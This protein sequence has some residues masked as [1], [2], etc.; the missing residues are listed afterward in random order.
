M[1]VDD[2]IRQLKEAT[3]QIPQGLYFPFKI[4]NE[5]WLTIEKYTQITAFSDKTTVFTVL[6]FP[7]I[8]LPN[9]DIINVIAL[10]VHDYSNIFTVGEVNSEIIAVDREKLTYLKMIRK[11]LEE[12]VKDKSQYIYVPK[13][14]ADLSREHKRTMRGANVYATAVLSL[15]H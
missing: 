2:I 5:D 11:E 8:A 1:P 15:L 6:R 4:H 3:Q 9:Y 12:C 14:N 13:S 10:P 7:L